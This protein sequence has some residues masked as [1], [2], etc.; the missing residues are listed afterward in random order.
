MTGGEAERGGLTDE[1]REAMVRGP[2]GA[3]TRDGHD[4]L[5]TREPRSTA[6]RTSVSTPRAGVLPTE[7]RPPDWPRG[8]RR[9][10]ARLGGATSRRATP[11]YNGPGGS[12]CS[13]SGR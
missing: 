11:Q 5:P 2:R 1:R 13:P 10:M 4:V 12:R 6:T 8:A 9:P 7:S 3:T